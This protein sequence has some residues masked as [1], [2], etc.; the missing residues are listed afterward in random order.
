MGPLIFLYEQLQKNELPDSDTLKAA[1]K[2][3]LSLMANAASHFSVERRKCIMKHLNNDLKPLAEA[4]Y[5]ERGP[6]LFI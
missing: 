1:V 6:Y 2:C 5:P 4:Q 3:S